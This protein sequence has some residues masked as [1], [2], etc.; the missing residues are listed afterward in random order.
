MPA[1]AMLAWFC[2]PV[3]RF[4]IGSPRPSLPGQGPNASTQ[5]TWASLVED[6][7]PPQSCSRL[8]NDTPT[9][10]SPSIPRVERSSLRFLSLQSASVHPKGILADFRVDPR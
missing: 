8:Q 3:S 10:R 7:G 9:L 1:A 5:S 2:S 6:T 4:Q